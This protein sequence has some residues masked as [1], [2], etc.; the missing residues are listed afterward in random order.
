MALQSPLA[1]IVLLHQDVVDLTEFKQRYT[2]P[3]NTYN[4]CNFASDY[5]KEWPQASKSLEH[6]CEELAGRWCSSRAN[7]SS[8]VVQM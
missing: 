5:E 6:L 2:H 4:T 1:H 3:H 7:Y 8:R